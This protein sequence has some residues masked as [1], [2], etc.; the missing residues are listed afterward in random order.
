MLR[1]CIAALVLVLLLGSSAGADALT[2]HDLVLEIAGYVLQRQ[3]NTLTDIRLATTSPAGA[4]AEI[5][6][7]SVLAESA[8]PSGP[9]IRVMAFLTVT[10]NVQPSKAQVTFL[11]DLALTLTSNQNGV[12]TL[13]M[14]ATG[15]PSA[16][17][18]FACNDWA[19][20]LVMSKA[21][22]LMSK[23]VV[24]V[25]LEGIDSLN[26]ARASGSPP[27]QVAAYELGYGW[28]LQI[29]AAVPG[30]CT[31]PPRIFLIGNAFTMFLSTNLVQRLADVQFASAA[32]PKRLTDQGIPQADGPIAVDRIVAR[33]G[34]D[35]ILLE[36]QGHYEDG[37]P[38]SAVWDMDFTQT[39]DGLTLNTRRITLNGVE[40][41]IPPAA[42]LINPLD[43]LVRNAAFGPAGSKL[44]AS[45]LGRVRLSVGSIR[46]EGVL[47]AGRA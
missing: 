34:T 22:E 41:A 17:A 45:P 20:D 14:E 2:G 31:P 10:Q 30:A 32:I 26:H 35:V 4:R 19:R 5:A 18:D 28:V 13:R 24:N 47:I 25:P 8:R 46:P 37:R 27:L 9:R 29:S 42:K 38:A 12:V 33:L 3:I 39:P 23:F 1:Y 16:A 40:M 7:D 36:W 43:E 11:T 15:C 44:F 6:V 21:P